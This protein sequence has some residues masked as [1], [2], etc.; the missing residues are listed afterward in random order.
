MSAF[1]Q[2]KL[3]AMSTALVII[4]SLAT[5]AALALVVGRYELGHEAEPTACSRA[6]DEVFADGASETADKVPLERLLQHRAACLGDAG[7]VDQARRLTGNTQ[8]VDEARTLLK[9][10]ERSAAFKTD[11]LKAE[12]AWL[13][14]GDAQ[15]ALTNGMEGRAE[16]LRVRAVSVANDLQSKWPEW[17]LPYRILEE[18]GRA[19]W[20]TSAGVQSTDY[21]QLERGARRRLVTGAFV[22]GLTDWQP[23]AY[24]FVV[25]A[26]GMLGLC[27]GVSG[28]VAMREM[29]RT[30]TTSIATAQP[31]YVELKG[32]LHL[33]PNA[34]PVIGPHSKLRGVWYEVARRSGFKGARTQY[35]QSLQPFLLRDVSGE[36]VIDPRGMTVRTRHSAASFGSDGGVSS[37]KR[38]LR[39]CSR[40]TMPRTFLE[41]SALPRRAE[42]VRALC[43][44][45]R[46]AAACWF[47]I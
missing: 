42:R 43:E 27:A 5:A 36:A 33:P 18:A 1:L 19:S 40:K 10:A 24:V 14:L 12:L 30:G 35:E 2:R 15:L 11:E 3:R 8:Q 34:A 25:A 29:T 9:D 6:L 37:S 47:R 28:L 22:R 16:E 41:N 7:Y 32:T 4:L 17:S 31:G 20:K 38:S 44:S 45:R 46:T 39:R 13:D 26:I 23:I 21:F